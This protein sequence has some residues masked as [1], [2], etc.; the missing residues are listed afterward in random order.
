MSRRSKLFNSLGL[1]FL[2]LVIFTLGLSIAKKRIYDS[3]LGINLL[4][5]TDGGMGVVSVRQAS[6]IAGITKLP[7]NLEIQTEPFGGVYLTE[8]FYKVGL[9]FKDS[10]D[11]ARIS[12]GQNLG[13]ALSA[14]V[15]GKSPLSLTGLR[16]ALLSFRT[17]TNLGLIDRYFL[18]KDITTLI[19]KGSVLEI[20]IP[21]NVVTNFEAPDG[22][23]ILKLN[24]A[25]FVW[26]RNKFTT[27]EVL[28]ETAELTVVNGSGF[29]GKARLVAR[30]IES[31]GGRVIDV[32]SARNE[33]SGWCLLA[34]DLKAHP[35]TVK[36]LKYSYNCETSDNIDLNDYIES[37]VKSDLVMI[38]GKRY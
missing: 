20:P 5:M 38:L 8:S 26:S 23:D 17:Q 24:P 32:L 35:Q 37:D 29:E 2:F 33:V 12:V 15:K 7:D 30:Q 19:G 25:V 36:F 3:N 18:L 1:I 16:E 28:S 22:K 4:L 14:V 11:I 34:G 27:D 21:R 31:A 9:P 13:V 10:L 6:G